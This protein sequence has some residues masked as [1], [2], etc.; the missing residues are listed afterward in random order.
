MAPGTTRSGSSSAPGRRSTASWRPSWSS[1]GRAPAA[2]TRGSSTDGSKLE[3]LGADGKVAKTLGPDTGLVAAVNGNGGGNSNAVPTWLITGTDAAGVAAAAKALTP[4]TLADRFALVVHGG[5]DYPVPFQGIVVIYRRR[6]SP[7]HA[8]SAAAA[9]GWCA[10]LVAATLIVSNPLM[11]GALLLAV[12]G[13]GVLAG[14]RH[15]LV[16]ALRWALPVALAIVVVNALVTRDGL[17][18]IWRFGNLPI[19]GYSYITAEATAYGAILGLRAVILILSGVLYTTCVDPDELLGAVSPDLLSLG[20]ERD[21]RDPAGAAAGSRRAATGRR[22]ALP[23]GSPAVTGGADARGH[24]QPAG[25]RARCRRR[26]RGPRL[27]DRAPAARV[28]AVRAGSVVAARPW[29][30]RLRGGRAGA[31]DRRPGVGAAGVLGLPDAVGGRR[32]WM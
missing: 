11:L 29:L 25:P 19:V 8:A 26:A 2:S 32:A 17:T 12:V 4:A 6:A 14:V 18:I 3:L 13:G 21:A 22:A 23:A 15:E 5:T 28:V 27:R 24:E 30:R 31:V 9:S 7:L 20:A 1:S 10:A 16:R